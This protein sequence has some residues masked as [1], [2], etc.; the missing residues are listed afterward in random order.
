MPT[1]PRVGRHRDLPAVRRCPL[2]TSEVNE[3]PN[4]KSRRNDF[5]TISSEDTNKTAPDAATRETGARLIVDQFSVAAQ[6]QLQRGARALID[7][8]G[9]A[10]ANIEA[11][12]AASR[13]AARGMQTLTQYATEQSD[14]STKRFVDG[15]HAL[16]DAKTPNEFVTAQ[17]ALFRSCSS[18]MT[19]S[20][21]RINDTLAQTTREMIDPWIGCV[22]AAIK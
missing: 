13:A 14:R 7:G 10:R 5:M 3:A 11:A 17:Q 18:D 20:L 21:S 2:K 1:R 8:N 4:P 9:M 19:S 12:M 16:T 22:I 15:L 6:R